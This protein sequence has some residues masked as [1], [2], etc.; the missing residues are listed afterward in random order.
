M[1]QANVKPVVHYEELLFC[2][3]GGC[4]LVKPVDHP[5]DL[6]SNQQYVRTS[7]VQAFDVDSGEFETRNTRYQPLPDAKR[8]DQLNAD[9]LGFVQ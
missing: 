4:A 3:V 8:S 5:G 9:V 2:T 6:V 1:T 7:T